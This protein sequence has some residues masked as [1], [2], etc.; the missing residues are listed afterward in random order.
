VKPALVI[1]AAG[2]SERLG[3][4]KSTVRIGE[5]S[6]LEHLLAAT[7]ECFD[8]EPALI[9]TGAHD[10]EI[11]CCLPPGVERVF[12]A[13]WESG[14]TGG[15]A[16]ACSRRPGRD[17]CVAPVDCPLVP[18]AV[19]EALLAAWRDHGAPAEGWLAPCR[20]EAESR[21]DGHPIVLGRE[22]AARLRTLSPDHSLRLVR[23]LARPRLALPVEEEAIHDD[24]DA[25]ADL[26]R[27]RERLAERGPPPRP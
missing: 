21:R 8:G 17:L 24:L 19:F 1:L 10:E 23:E 27:L 13:G 20:G 15:L 2:R 7:R 5:C 3:T 14:R 12:H 26:E 16:L 18:G 22:L 4:C 9:V 25:P 11:A 6:A